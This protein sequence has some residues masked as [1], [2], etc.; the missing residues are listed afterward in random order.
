MAGEFLR[1]QRGSTFVS[2]TRQDIF[3]TPNLGISR[4][5]SGDKADAYPRQ[6]DS[7]SV[8]VCI[9]TRGLFRGRAACEVFRAHCCRCR[10]SGTCCLRLSVDFNANDAHRACVITHRPVRANR[11]VPPSSASSPF[12]QTPSPS[13]GAVQTKACGG[14]PPPMNVV[15]REI[16]TVCGSRPTA[17]PVATAFVAVLRHPSR[18]AAVAAM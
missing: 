7:T 9:P 18:D 13:C 4:G 6:G 16:Q 14:G 1:L 3:H 15:Q 5:T 2:V 11:R 17:A 8:A 12:Q 10:I